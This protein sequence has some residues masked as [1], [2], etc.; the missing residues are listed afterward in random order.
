MKASPMLRIV[1]GAGKKKKRAQLSHR[2]E[3][4]EKREGDDSTVWRGK[5]DRRGHIPSSKRAFSSSRGERR[6]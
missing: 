3:E 1:K 4:G 6:R 5:S 2:M